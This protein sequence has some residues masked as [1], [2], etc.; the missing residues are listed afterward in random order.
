MQLPDWLAPMLAAALAV[1]T[2][3]AFWIGGRPELGA[4]WAGVNIAF[5]L[6]LALGRRNDTIRL[7]SAT[8]DDERTRLLEYQATSAAGLVLVVA[9]AVLFLADAVRG[10]T[11]LVYGV[12]LLL[13]ETTRVATL[14]VLNRRG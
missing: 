10:E 2:F 6:V 13:A 11:G 12:L 5:A 1:P 14:A 4:V 3:V 7:V 9:L 8:E